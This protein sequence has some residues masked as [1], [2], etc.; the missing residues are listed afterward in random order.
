MQK[1]GLLE[2]Q[3]IHVK[4]LAVKQTDFLEYLYGRR[5]IWRKKETRDLFATRIKN[6]INECTDDRTD[7]MDMGSDPEKKILILR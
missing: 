2:V 3:M 1:A 4:K 6:I 7:Y 5:P